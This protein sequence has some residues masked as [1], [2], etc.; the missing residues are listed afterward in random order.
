MNIND[1]THDQL[2]E[3][4]A[5][6]QEWKLINDGLGL[7]WQK[8]DSDA[9]T[10]PCSRYDPCHFG[11]QAMDLLQLLPDFEFYKHEDGTFCIGTSSMGY[12]VCAENSMVAIVKAVIFSKF[13]EEVE[14]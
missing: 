5:K 1:L 2:N 11:D 9:D 7:L 8:S 13:G 12:L 10:I 4:A 6:T 14:V 3:L